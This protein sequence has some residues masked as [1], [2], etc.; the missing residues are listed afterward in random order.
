MDREPVVPGK[1]PPAGIW[2]VAFSAALLTVIGCGAWAALTR[3][4]VLASHPSSSYALKATTIT[5]GADP[6]SEAARRNLQLQAQQ[7]NPFVT[8][9]REV[10]GPT[11]SEDE[12]NALSREVNLS[13]CG[14]SSSTE[15][16]DHLTQNGL[17]RKTAEDVIAAVLAVEDC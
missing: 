12:L 7:P 13:L 4:D 6:Y 17:A 15:A 3:E 5:R 14:G 2:V 9:I 8:A 1:G 16:V 11:M 10:V